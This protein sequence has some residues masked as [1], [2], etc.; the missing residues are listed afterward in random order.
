MPRKPKF[1]AY[2]NGSSWKNGPMAEFN[3][4]REARAWA[5]EYGNTADYCNICTRGGKLVAQHVRERNA[6]GTRW[7][8]GFVE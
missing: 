6:N 7:F 2:I 1:Q 8:R 3:T 5:E 4:I